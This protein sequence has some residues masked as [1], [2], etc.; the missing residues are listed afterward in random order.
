[1]IPHLTLQFF[2]LACPAV[3]TNNVEDAVECTT[4]HHH[5]KLIIGTESPEATAEAFKDSM[6]GSIREGKLQNIL[7]E[8]YPDSNVFIVTG[9]VA[10]T[11]SPT[12]EGGVSGGPIGAGAAAGIGIAAVVAVAAIGALLYV[13]RRRA[14]RKDDEEEFIPG[15]QTSTRVVSQRDAEGDIAPPG[16]GDRSL[17][18]TPQDFKKSRKASQTASKTLAEGESDVGQ[19]SAEGGADS[20]SNAGS[21]GWSSS[22]GVS[23]LNTGSIDSMDIVDKEGM[24]AA[25]LAAI[26]ATSAIAGVSAIGKSDKDG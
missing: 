3:V 13:N 12:K 22:A 7:G 14:A 24:H 21:S 6:E 10:T 11:E 2:L 5:L 1:M 15:E 16:V 8:E 23:S 25:S 26:G 17:G 19:P 18:A 4:V 9:Y 20:S